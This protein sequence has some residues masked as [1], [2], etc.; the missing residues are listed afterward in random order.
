MTQLTACP[1]C[2]NEIK[3]DETFCTGCGTK[4]VLTLEEKRNKAA[5][6]GMKVSKQVHKGKVKSGRTV[7]LVLA[8]LFL[9]G[10]PIVYFMLQSEIKSLSNQGYVIDT[11]KANQIMILFVGAQLFLAL[12]YIGL[13]FWAKTKPFPASLTAL[14]LFL[15]TLGISAAVDPAELVKGLLIK[16]IIIIAL[17]NSVSSAYKYKKLTEADI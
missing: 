4:L 7:I 8:I 15:A 16:I 14:L 10:A 6:I 17:I 12:V 5:V 9:I 2:G 11:A 1:K 13:W 3:P